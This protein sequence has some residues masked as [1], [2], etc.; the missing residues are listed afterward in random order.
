MTEFLFDGTVPDKTHLQ[1]R[2]SGAAFGIVH[3]DAECDLFLFHR[4]K[5][6]DAPQLDRR[7]RAFQPDI[8][9]RHASMVSEARTPLPE[10]RISAFQKDGHGI[11]RPAEGGDVDP[12]PVRE[13]SV[14]IRLLDK[15]IDETPVDVNS[16][17]IRGHLFKMEEKPSL[18]HGF[19][20]AETPLVPSGAVL[21]QRFPVPRPLLRN[22]FSF[23][24]PVN[25]KQRGTE[26]SRNAHITECSG[27]G[28]KRR[29]IIGWI[30]AP[31]P[32]QRDGTANRVLPFRRIVQFPERSL[33]NSGF[34]RLKTV[35]VQIRFLRGKRFYGDDAV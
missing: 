33:R 14:I 22:E 17:I 13:R 30:C 2:R 21:N 34:S 11:L 16:R 32:V 31:E 23:L 3:P 18:F 7:L 29:I 24:R 12:P 6:Q 1:F 9:E 5:R 4:G 28:R 10:F 35:P 25:F 27:R 8:S 19:R 26:T 20:H 15:G